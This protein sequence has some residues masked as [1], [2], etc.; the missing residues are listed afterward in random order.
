MTPEWAGSIRDVVEHGWG[1]AQLIG[2]TA[3][4]RADDPEFREW[5]MRAERMSASPQAMLNV[6]DTI[7]RTDVREI[8]GSV[9]A[10]TLVLHR[11]DD[12]IES[13]SLARELAESIPQARFVELPGDEAFYL[14]GDVDSL[15]QE[16]QEFLTGMRGVPSGDRVLATLLFSD[17]VDSTARASALGDARG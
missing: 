17:I 11:R 3:P 7:T 10:P 5:F 1:Q 9:R 8:L 13:G 4:S 2:V 16:V 6:L 14:I 15:V 12:R